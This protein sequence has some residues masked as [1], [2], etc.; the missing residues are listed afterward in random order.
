MLTRTTNVLS[1]GWAAHWTGDNAATWDDLL[2][3]VTGVLDAGLMGLPMIGA[4]PRLILHYM[5]ESVLPDA[6]LVLLFR[7]ASFKVRWGSCLSVY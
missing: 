1:S 7:Q 4:P 6:D 3:S 5:P 2:W